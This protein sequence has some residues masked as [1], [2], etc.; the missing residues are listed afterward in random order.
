MEEFDR[1]LSHLLADLQGMSMYDFGWGSITPYTVWAIITLI[2]VFALVWA[3]RSRITFI[4]KVS[5]LLAIEAVVDYIKVE[6]GDALLGAHAREHMPFLL[7]IFFFILAGNLI[8]LIPGCKSA[9][10]TMS[11]T[12]VLSLSSFCY[13]NYAGAK[14]QGVMHYIASLAPAGLPPGVNVA[15]WAIE[16]FSMSLRIFALAIRLFANMFAGHLTMGCFAILTSLYFLPLLES[17][18]MENLTNGVLSGL[19][20]LILICVYA[21]EFMVAFIQAY[22]FTLLSGVYIQLATSEH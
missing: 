9:T 2:A 4:P 18:T 3:L 6:I 8:G 19:W 10:G 14:A 11:V 1:E 5:P 15:V 17:F 16:A 13:F 7:T 21:M 12:L 22:V 20:L